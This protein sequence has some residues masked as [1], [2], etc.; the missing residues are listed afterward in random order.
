[1][2]KI[3]LPNFFYYHN[4]NINL[5]NLHKDY[6]EYFHENICFY[7][8]E[9]NFP[10][11]YWAGEKNYNQKTVAYKDYIYYLN[12]AT[13]PLC[14]DCSNP[15]LNDKDFLDSAMNVMLDTLQNGSNK[16]IISSIETLNCLKAKYPYYLYIGSEFY[17]A[18]DPELQSLNELYKVKI[19]HQNLPNYPHIPKNKIQVIINNPCDNCP[20]VECLLN[21]WQNIYNFKRESYFLNCQKIDITDSSINWELIEKLSEQGYTNFGFNSRGFDLT[22]INFIKRLYI[23]LFVRPQYQDKVFNLL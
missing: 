19:Y 22:D 21:E 14:L 18:S 11:H 17:L 8:Q 7:E 1:M 9:G 20:T 6:P 3:T 10:F 2:I 4:I 15:L 13:V 23:K 5:I 12:N 16:I